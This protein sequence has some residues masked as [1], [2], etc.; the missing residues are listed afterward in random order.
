M[1]KRKSYNQPMQTLLILSLLA[2]SSFAATPR[3][4]FNAAVARVKAEPTDFA[5]R[6]K[7]ILLG[8]MLRP[9]VPEEAERQLVRGATFMKEASDQEGFE[10]AAQAFQ[11]AANA[12]PWWSHA[13]YNLGVAREAA[14]D[15]RAALEAFRSYLLTKPKDAA[16]VKRRVYALEALIELRSQPAKAV[17]QQASAMEGRWEAEG[18]GHVRCLDLRRSGEAYTLKLC[19]NVDPDSFQ[20][21]SVTEQ[22]VDF[23][24][25]LQGPA[26]SFSLRREG[27][28]LVGTQTNLWNNERFSV[29]YRRKQP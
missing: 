13:Y 28:A 20:G 1:R 22:T 11:A 8:M 2:P 15:P 25:L 27:D 10:R 21:L 5:A 19:L 4:E 16:E 18:S 7:A 26:S 29:R 6:E 14:K 24:Y 23:V 9:A 17:P 12:A 3:E